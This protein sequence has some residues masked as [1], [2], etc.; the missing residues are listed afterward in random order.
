[1]SSDTTG[2]QGGEKGSS[3]VKSLLQPLQ[4]SEPVLS[5]DG[6]SSKAPKVHL[7]NGSEFIE[8]GR[9]SA[10][11]LDMRKSA[12]GPKQVQLAQKKYKVAEGQNG[13]SSN[14]EGTPLGGEGYGSSWK[15]RRHGNKIVPASPGG[16]SSAPNT[17]DGQTSDEGAGARTSTSLKDFP[18]RRRSTDQSKRVNRSKSAGDV[19]EIVK[20]EKINGKSAWERLRARLGMIQQL[21]RMR[22]VDNEL[23]FL[24]SSTSL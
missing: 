12:G 24:T 17:D 9:K 19:D 20:K 2:S 7:V 6:T 3:D 10:W 14:V 16:H 21:S 15:P 18:I 1:M 11:T 23:K 22:K 5:S 13:S 4:F 8:N